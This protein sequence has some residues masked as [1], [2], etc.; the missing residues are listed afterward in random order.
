MARK[1]PSE[2]GFE[3]GVAFSVA[4][5]GVCSSPVI[6]PRA[7]SVAD[8]VYVAW[9]VGPESA[10]KVGLSSPPLWTRW[11]GIVRVMNADPTRVRLRAN[12]WNDK[13]R[14][15]AASR[16]HAIEV[17]FKPAEKAEITYAS[18]E[19]FGSVSLAASE[20]RFLDW[21]YAPSFGKALGSRSE[22]L[23]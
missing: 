14:L 5:D 22:K 15:L 4:L 7:K 18:D 10:L 17:W 11:S 2:F 12:E 20:E 1:H 6:A 21:Y 13:Q 9:L 3:L 19:G 8:V 16:G 23:T